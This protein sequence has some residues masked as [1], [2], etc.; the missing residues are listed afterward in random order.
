MNAINSLPNETTSNAFYKLSLLLFF[1]LIIG[2]AGCNNENS[3]NRDYLWDLVSQQCLPNSS[4]GNETNPC[5]IVDNQNR[6]AILKDI[7]GPLQYLLIPTTKITG[8][9]DKALL[10]DS[11]PNYMKLAWDNRFLLSKLYRKEI[12]DSNIVLSINSI[13][14]RTQD[15]LHIHIDCIDP[16]V[17]KLINNKS[18]NGPLNKWGNWDIKINHH[19]YRAALLDEN[20]LDKINAFNFLAQDLSDGKHENSPRITN[21]M[22]KHSLALMKLQGLDKLVLLDTKLSIGNPAHAEETSDHSCLVLNGI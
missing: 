14:G 1:Q 21:L 2:I 7:N 17:K 4:A 19:T 13:E 3:N 12:D 22:S 9:E 5:V 8:I 11:Q 18:W 6:Y 16:F 15:Q 10:D 20:Q